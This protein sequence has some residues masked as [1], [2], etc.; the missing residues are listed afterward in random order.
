MKLKITLPALMAL[1]FALTCQA[2]PDEE[3][4]PAELLERT[5]THIFDQVN[6][7]HEYYEKN[8]EALRDIVKVDLMPLL[9]TR[10]TGRLI[11][12]TE[13]RKAS[14]EQ[15]D[16]FVDAMGGLLISRYSDG[17]LRF[18]SDKQLQVLPIK[19][20][21]NPRLTRVRSR[22]QLETGSY[23]PVDYAF[24]QTRDG[25]KV[26]DVIVEGISYVTTFRNQIVPQVQAEGLDAVIEKLNSGNI[27]FEN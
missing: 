27:E 21:L 6:A 24:R 19:G 9:D 12:A 13:G 10:Y 25:W 20:E 18:R 4:G 17:L 3:I 22:V 26:F 8:P 23:A 16:A 5:A 2:A 14:P 11:L 15:I 7:N 1:A